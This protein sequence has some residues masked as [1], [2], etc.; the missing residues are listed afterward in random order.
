MRQSNIRVSIASTVVALALLFCGCGKD[1]AETS[2]SPKGDFIVKVGNQ[3]LSAADLAKAIPAGLSP[4]DSSRYTR[5]YVTEWINSHLVSDYAASEIDM[6]EIDRLTEE[7]RNRLILLEY[8]RRLF[9]SQADSIKSDS[10]Q[11]YY[12][13]HKK[14]F[15]LQHPLVKGTY[16]KIP[17][18][19]ANINILRRLYR[20]T[21]PDDIDRLEKESLS[22]AIHYD[23]FRDNWVDWEQIETKIPYNF[24]SDADGWLRANN[25]L[26]IKNGNF[27]YLL[28][29]SDYLPT[30]HIMPLE[31]ARGQVVERLMNRR[32]AEFDR[33][34]SRNLYTKALESGRLVINIPLE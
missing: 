10:I 26:D 30:G 6:Q 19:A 20:S 18:H 25:T 31:Q 12:E 22:S 13:L 28:F 15:V 32:R 23:Y 16:L 21:K 29:I 2:D 5:V 27:V 7:Y 14:D 9:Q 24:G 4:E 17:T 8:R 11:A 34:I 3:M 33:E 1:H